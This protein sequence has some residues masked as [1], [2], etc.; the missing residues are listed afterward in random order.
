MKKISLI[1]LVFLAGIVNVLAAEAEVAALPTPEPGLGISSIELLIV[2]AFV[3]VCLMLLVASSLLNASKVMYA[4][5]TNPTPLLDEEVVK[6]LDY[7]VW[8]KSKKTKP[9]VWLKLLSLKPIEQEKDLIIDHA[10]DGI[11]ELDNPIPNWFNVLFYGTMIFAAG[12]LF[13]YHIGGYGDLQDVEYEKEIVKADADKQLYLANAANAIDENSVEADNTPAVLEEGKSIFNG[14][15]VVC[16]GD[17]GKGG[18]GPN[19]ADEF[20]LHGGGV[21]NVFKTIK[22]GV[23]EKGMVSWE[24]NLSPKQI[25]AVTNY[26]LSLQGTKPAGAKAPQ[27][28]KYV[29]TVEKGAGDEE[30]ATKQ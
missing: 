15:C 2:L 5:Q 13:Y 30:I 12:Y 27:G 21:K 19:L 16:H 26:I 29:E 23:P 4:E 18:I 28:E 6:P 24:K 1:A 14:N 7:E 25:S 3:F 20:W 9:S 17:G 11:H 10:Y 8:L 22:Y